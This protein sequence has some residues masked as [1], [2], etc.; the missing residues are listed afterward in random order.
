MYAIR[1][2]APGVRSLILSEVHKMEDLIGRQMVKLREVLQQA[3]TASKKIKE[4]EKRLAQLET[5]IRVCTDVNKVQRDENERLRAQSDNISQT[6]R[7]QHDTIENQMNLIADNDAIIGEQQ[8]MIVG[9]NNDSADHSDKRAK[10]R[11]AGPEPVD[12]GEGE[13]E[14]EGDTSDEDYRCETGRAQ[15]RLKYVRCRQIKAR[16][17][18]RCDAVVDASIRQLLEFA[19]VRPMPCLRVVKGKG[20]TATLVASSFKTLDE[21][22]ESKTKTYCTKHVFEAIKTVLVERQMMGVD[23]ENILK[24]YLCTKTANKSSNAPMDVKKAICQNGKHIKKGRHLACQMILVFFG[25]VE[26]IPCE[27]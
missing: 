6:I 15:K 16:D 7:T 23:Q 22:S 2:M 4:Q 18:M 21:I 24:D 1:R 27:K 5:S 11:K 10:G 14:G 13:G 9:H 26:S 8:G 19:N 25:V 12:K 3:D 17:E 20:E